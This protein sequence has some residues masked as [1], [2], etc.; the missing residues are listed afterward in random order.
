[1]IDEIHNSTV[2]WSILFLVLFGS[3]IFYA[4]N[5]HQLIESLDNYLKQKQVLSMK[6]F[7][8]NVYYKRA[9]KLK[10]W[11]FIFLFVCILII[12]A[13]KFELIYLSII[14][15]TLDTYEEF[16]TVQEYFLKAIGVISFFYFFWSIMFFTFNVK[17]IYYVKNTQKLIDSFVN[18]QRK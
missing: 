16:P 18:Y 1:M 11:R 14:P 5:I 6:S 9:K 17:I 7:A 3:M 8:N 12:F 4:R 10:P 13:V 2:F 15:D